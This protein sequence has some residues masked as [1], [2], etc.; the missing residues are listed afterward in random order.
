MFNK[1]LLVASMAAAISA[2]MVAQVQAMRLQENNI[3]Q[4]G[5]GPLYM[6][7]TSLNTEIVVVNTRTDAAVKAKIVFREGKTSSEVLDFILYLSPGD[8]WRGQVSGT[9]SAAIMNS[10]DDSMVNSNGNFAS[11]TNVVA[12]PFFDKNNSGSNGFGHFELIGAYSI[13]AG[14][15]DVGES[16]DVV[17]KIGMSKTDLKKIVDVTDTAG[18]PGADAFAGTNSNLPGRLQLMSEVQFTDG[19][20]QGFAQYEVPMLGPDTYGVACSAVAIDMPNCVINNDNFNAILSAD[21]TMGKN[22]GVGPVSHINPIETAIAT[23]D[24]GLEYNVENGN[25][26]IPVVSFVT[27][28]VH[29]GGGSATSTGVTTT[30]TG[31]AGCTAGSDT[32]GIA[33]AP[34][35]YGYSAPFQDTVIGEVIYGVTSWDNSEGYNEATTDQFSGGTTTTSKIPDE[36]NLLSITHYSTSGW[37]NLLYT[38]RPTCT[39]SG[40]P[41]ITATL[42]TKG[43]IIFWAENGER[44]QSM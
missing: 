25:V 24:S 43:N 35:I 37:T 16:K 33:S 10:T 7:G 13:N 18:G 19:N 31:G 2:G 5:L 38:A 9:A 44:R 3:G 17:V 4:V 28:Y 32:D 41:A 20:G 36:V 27:K 6:A 26:A 21:S 34:H 14:S 42:K 29:A 1:K 39:Y 40:V 11:S 12:Q 15:Y 30:P 23:K 8:V 22:F